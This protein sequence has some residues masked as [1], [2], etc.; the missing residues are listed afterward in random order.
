[1][2]Q[3]EEESPLTKPFLRKFFYARRPRRILFGG[4]MVLIVLLICSVLFILHALSHESTDD[5]YIDGTI[6]SISPRINGHVAKVLVTDNQWV[7]AGEILVELDPRDYKAKYNMAKAALEIARATAK[8][9]DI[10]VSLT[11]ISSL[12][13][14]DE[15]HSAAE[16][17]SA[18]IKSAEA[19]AS[20]FA[21]LRDE[22]K[23]QLSLAKASLA[24]SKAAMISNKAKHQRDAVDLKRAREMASS[25]TIT[26]QELDHAGAAEGISA[27]ELEAAKRRIDTQKA[28]VTQAEAALAAAEDNL[29]Q[30][31]AQIEVSKAQEQEAQ[32]RL[33]SA[34]SAPQ[35]VAQ[36][37]ALARASA[38]DLDRTSAELKLASLQLSY[39]KVTAP[40]GGYITHKSV[41]QGA[42]VQVG[43]S[44]LAIVPA[45]IWVTANFKETQLTHMQPGQKVSITVDTFPDVTF[46]GHVDS[47]Q[48][49]TGSQFSLLP[50][51]NATGNFI[52]VVQRV[53]VKIVFDKTEQ[54]RKYPI[55]IGLSACPEVDISENRN[56]PNKTALHIT[57]PLAADT[58]N[59]PAGYVQ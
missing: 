56:T 7:T 11:E 52:K 35:Q 12:S 47:I 1:M 25:G 46:Q 55:F 30:N 36:S 58:R 10:S 41:E 18:L 34:R 19:Q 39:T 9:K 48:H 32:A 21:G 28:M 43:Q 26:D 51:E 59:R 31:R 37:H 57:Q 42:F 20:A 45:D 53:P 50:P 2:E 29:R 5:A 49:G 54:L 13:G 24:Q 6:V 23:A 33:A 3:H 4:G 44:L 40:V 8:S 16:A 14:L 22:A 27:A 15:A 17:A 38:A